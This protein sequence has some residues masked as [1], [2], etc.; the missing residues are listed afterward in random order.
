MK[1]IIALIITVLLLVSALSLP[2]FADETYDDFFGEHETFE[3]T[4]TLDP[5]VEISFSEDFK[6]LYF[7]ETEYIRFSTE[8]IFAEVE[9]NIKNPIILTET[10]EDIIDEIGLKASE[11]GNLIDAGITYSD[12][13]N[14]YCHY[15]RSDSYKEYNSL[16]KDDTAPYSIDFSYP[17]G[18]I[19]TT[20]KDKLYTSEKDNIKFDYYNFDYEYYVSIFSK[21]KSFEIVTGIIFAY[22]DNVYYLDYNEIGKSFYEFDSYE[23]ENQKLPVHK[24]TDLTLL[25]ELEKAEKL[26][27]EDD[28]GFFFD[29]NFTKRISDIFIIFIFAILPFAALVTFTIFA[30]R[31]KRIYR[32]LCTVVAGLCAAE[33]IVFTIIAIIVT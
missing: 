33:L 25:E 13:A 4:T 3:Y 18:N 22:E 10:Q 17:E 26:S 28:Y 27:Y 29:D 32:K 16:L 23:L 7:G 14:L 20:T 2:V 19:V 30:I 15:I 21:D 9:A 11:K 8:K 24:I 12:G 31:S 6:T 1:K 5:N